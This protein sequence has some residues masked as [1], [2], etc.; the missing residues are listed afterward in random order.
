MKRAKIPV[1]DCFARLDLLTPAFSL[2]FLYHPTRPDDAAEGGVFQRAPSFCHFRPLRNFVFHFHA[3]CGVASEMKCRSPA[4]LPDAVGLMPS[5]M[6]L[7]VKMKA[8]CGMMALERL[9]GPQW[10]F[11]S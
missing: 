8:M 4:N 11:A 10:L 2:S 6:I 9:G 7:D 5:L 1:W 3:L